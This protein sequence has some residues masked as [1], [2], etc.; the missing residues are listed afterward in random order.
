[1]IGGSAGAV[2]ALDLLVRDLPADLPAAVFVCVHFPASAKSIL[3][4]MFRRHGH[5]PANHALDGTA[6][7]PGQ[8][9]VAPPGHHLTFDDSHVVLTRGPRENGHR[10]AIDA[11]MRSAARNFGPRVIGVVLSGVLD[12][13]TAGLLAVKHRGGLAVVQ[14]P[15]DAEHPSMPQSAIDHVAV[16]HVVP[17]AEMG[18]LLVELV[19]ENLSDDPVT[20]TQPGHVDLLATEDAMVAMDPGIVRQPERPGVPSPFSCPDCGGVLWELEDGAVLRF[21]C[22]TG[23]AWTAASLVAQQETAVEDALWAALRALEET[24]A[25]NQRL[26]DRAGD[27]QAVR[28]RFLARADAA[29]QQGDVI[30]QMLVGSPLASQDEDSA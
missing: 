19:H 28:R 13:G 21:R 9:T 14:D 22:R 18:K 5:L 4:Q 23:H 26:A 2:R 16:D 30:R 7:V 17:L 20:R 11:T 8:I 12:D 1:V 3:P 24:A 6:V 25:H 15:E 29:H 10:P 27:V